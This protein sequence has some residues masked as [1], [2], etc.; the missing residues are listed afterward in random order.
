[1]AANFR[2]QRIYL[3]EVTYS[4]TLH[5]LLHR[6]R[7]VDNELVSSLLSHHSRLLRAER[8]EDPAVVF[9]PKR[10]RAVLEKKLKSMTNVGDV[11]GNMP[12]PLIKDLEEVAPWE[13]SYDRTPKVSSLLTVA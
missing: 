6:L 9:V 10:S 13:Y 7:D 2:E 4:T 12:M 3:C 1:M 11:D 5:P 8:L